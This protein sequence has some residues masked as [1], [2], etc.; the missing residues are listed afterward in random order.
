MRKKL[1]FIANEIIRDS[2]RLI[3]GY[4]IFDMKDPNSV[5]IENDLGEGMQTSK[6]RFYNLMNTTIDV[7]WQEE[8]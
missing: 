3:G 6:E 2:G 1:N 4:E 5:F 8:F 7:Y